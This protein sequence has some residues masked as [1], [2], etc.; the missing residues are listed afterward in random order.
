[1]ISLTKGL[2]TTA[3]SLGLIAGNKDQIEQFFEEV[4]DE[5]Q[6]V[7]T[8]GDMRSISNML[9]FHY[10]KKGRYPSEANF[11]NWLEEG[12]KENSFR[13]VY[14][15][16]WGNSFIYTTT[17]RNKTFTLISTGKDGII[18]SDDDMIISGP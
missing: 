13:E 4:M 6:R 5:T 9:D 1:M 2:I 3:M 14:N 18:N 8:A 12:T 15:D 10:I 11:V 17:T 7:T 16:N